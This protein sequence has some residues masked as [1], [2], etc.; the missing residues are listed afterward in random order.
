MDEFEKRFASRAD[1]LL[2]DLLDLAEGVDLDRL[3]SIGKFG[4]LEIVSRHYYDDGFLDEAD[5]PVLHEIEGAYKALAQPSHLLAETSP[6][7]R[8][9]V[10]ATRIERDLATGIHCCLKLISDCRSDDE[11][12]VLFRVACERYAFAIAACGTN[13]N[14]AAEMAKLRHAE[15]R[16]LIK[17][18]VAH[19]RANIDPTLSAQKA[20]TELTKVVP[21]SHKKLAEIISAAKKSTS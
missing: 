13:R 17:D 1:D 7:V 14:P 4:W 16:E 11:A 3:F 21:L 12:M 5:V 2:C 10:N 18:A 9:W 19:W 15:S 8:A 6:F 20:A